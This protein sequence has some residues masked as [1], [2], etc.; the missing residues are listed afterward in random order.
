MMTTPSESA[1]QVI[2]QDPERRA[3]HVNQRDDAPLSELAS[4]RCS[5]GTSSGISDW[6]EGIN[7]AVQAQMLA[8]RSEQHPHR[9]R[10]RHQQH[11]RD[12]HQVV[13]DHD[14]APVVRFGPDAT[15]RRRNDHRQQRGHRDEAHKRRVAVGELRD[16]NLQGCDGRKAPDVR[17]DA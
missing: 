17:Q 9:L 5:L 15:Y 11:Q 16:M 12:A 2:D 14:G 4:S 7:S 13:Y 1:A 6:R 10:G 3:E 8:W